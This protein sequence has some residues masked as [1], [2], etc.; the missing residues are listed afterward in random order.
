MILLTGGQ[1]VARM[2]RD[3]GVRYMFG[4]PGGQ[5]YP[6]YLGIHE[7]EPDIQHV[8]FRCEKC[9]A[10]AAD[11]YARVTGRPAVCDAI[12][13]PGATNIVSGV[14]EAFGASSPL[15][16]ITSDVY[17]WMIGKNANQEADLITMLRPFTKGSFYVNRTDKIPELIRMAFRI[18]TT[19]RP[20]PVHLDFPA[21]ILEGQMDFG[22]NLYVEPAYSRVPAQRVAPDPAA[23]AEVASV[24]LKAKRPL[25]FAGG[26][27]IHSAAYAELRDL[28]ELLACPVTTSSMG[29]GAISE[30]HP[31]SIGVTAFVYHP[32]RLMLS[33]A[34]QLVRDADLVIFVGHRTEQFSTIDWTVPAPGTP[35]VH[36]DIDPREI[37][38]N[39]PVAAGLVGDAKLALA[40]LTAE[41]RG[42]L[43]RH[44][45]RT[46]PRTLETQTAVEAWREAI[47]AK[48][49]SDEVP[50]T[51]HRILEEINRFADRDAIFAC[52]AGLA[53]FW[54]AVFLQSHGTG[55]ALV[56]PR[57]MAGIGTGL[58]ATIGAQLAA[59]GRQVIGFGG[60]G[61][62][63][64][65]IHELE[66]M[67]RTG[68]NATY[69]LLNNTCFGYGTQV[70]R[71]SNV[72][73]VSHNFAP[74]NYADAARAFG[75]FGIRVEHADEL[76]GALRA[77]RESG[78]P[79][80]VEVITGVELPTVEA[81]VLLT[82]DN[83]VVGL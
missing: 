5:T 7:L 45:W 47:G 1:A 55:R 73:I 18:A 52:D 56:S 14:A 49:H 71:N 66:T 43:P 12:A 67:R 11:A 54:T 76:S 27:V 21:D 59:P 15:I 33:R 83:A 61:G 50:I 62:F 69:V 24:I 74:V 34:V 79:A 41:L 32:E 8:L 53:S 75:C 22:S 72:P 68:A 28:A 42:R 78:L 65:S 36:I 31:L 64:M 17:T 39:Y 82:P 40:A 30:D 9:A 6:I 46:A 37:G 58:P 16:A 13:G 35:V 51:A 25:I 20:G 2:L 19:G 57:G 4:I 60:D 10:M 63:A 77:A 38:R 81:G 23:V 48:M 3:Y 44:D 70:L 80:L 26:G 29:K